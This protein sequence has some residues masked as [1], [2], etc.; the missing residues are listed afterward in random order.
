MT[1][2]QFMAA[3]EMQLSGEPFAEAM[4][5]DLR[6]YVCQSGSCSPDT[7]FDPPLND[8]AA[9][10]PKGRIDLPGFFAR[11]R[12]SRVFEAANEQHRRRIGSGTSLVFGPVLNPSGASGSD[13]QQ[14]LRAWVQR[15]ALEANTVSRFVT[16]VVTPNNPVGWPG[17][18]PTLQPYAVWNPTIAASDA[19]TGCSISSDDDPG[20]SESLTCDDHDCD[21]ATLHLPSRAAQIR[22]MTIDPG[23]SG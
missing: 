17:L 10:G 12:V 21:Y 4:G 8:G 5:R 23:S 15:L 3:V 22:S 6:G 19:P 7:Y 14:L 9:G 20:G 13:A 1:R 16:A 11:R 2:D 18:W